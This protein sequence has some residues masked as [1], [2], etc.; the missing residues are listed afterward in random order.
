MPTLIILKIFKTLFRIIA[1]SETWINDMRHMRCKSRTVMK[2]KHCGGGW[3]GGGTLCLTTKIIMDKRQI[4]ILSCI[5]GAPGY[6]HFQ[7]FNSILF[8]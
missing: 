5:Y 6:E 3:G 4:M 7:R 1:I 2:T 8:I